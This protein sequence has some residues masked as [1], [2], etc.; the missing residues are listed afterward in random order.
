MARVIIGIPEMDHTFFRAYM[1]S[2]YLF[3]LWRA[4]AKVKTL[5]WTQDEREIQKY[6]A[7]CDGILLP[8][9]PDIDPALYGQ[10][11]IAACGKAHP[12]RDFLEL[13]LARLAVQANKPVLGICRGLQVLNVALGGS[14]LQDITPMQKRQHSDYAGRAGFAHRSS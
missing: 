8:G 13:R 7:E 10:Q 12:E 11:A 1:R 5:R 4:G 14:L 3:A 6:V 2:K 9:G